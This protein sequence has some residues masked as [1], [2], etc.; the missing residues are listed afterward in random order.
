[1]S[2][3]LLNRAPVVN[4]KPQS[5]RDLLVW[6]KGIALSKMVYS[7]TAKFPSEEKFGLEH[8]HQSCSDGLILTEGGLLGFWLRFRSV[9]G[10]FKP[11]PSRKPMIGTARHKPQILAA[12]RY[13]FSVNALVSQMRRA[14]G[15]PRP[16]AKPPKLA[17]SG[18]G[19]FSKSIF[20]YKSAPMSQM[21]FVKRPSS[22][23]P[24][25][26]GEGETLP[27]F[28]EI[29]V[30]GLANDA[31]GYQGTWPKN[32]LPGERI[33]V[34]AGSLWTAQRRPLQNGNHLHFENTP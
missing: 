28:L 12:H 11:A 32:P 20:G 34:R 10:F 21:K 22:P 6:Q 13:I 33:Q 4:G 19:V 7:L 26:P 15:R 3:E 27:A 14:V 9:K 2:D 23:Q 29:P 16:A 24:S 1:M 8:F 31:I 30:T 5:Y 25:P 17:A 18:Y